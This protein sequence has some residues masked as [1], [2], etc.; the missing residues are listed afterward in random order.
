[1]AAT[2][3]YRLG[4]SQIIEGYHFD[5]GHPLSVVSFCPN[6]VEVVIASLYAPKIRSYLSPFDVIEDDREAA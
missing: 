3:H 1:M 2:K 4:R 5:V 6:I